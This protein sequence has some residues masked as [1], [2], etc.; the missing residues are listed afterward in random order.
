MDLYS[1]GAGR[2]SGYIES[3]PLFLSSADKFRVSDT[4]RTRES[5][6]EFFRI[7]LCQST[8]QR[9]VVGEHRGKIG[10]EMGQ[11][12]RKEGRKKVRENVSINYLKLCLL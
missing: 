2:Y 7:P 1:L 9:S 5:R 8:D 4:I 12:E 6:C 3:F 10:K 11:N